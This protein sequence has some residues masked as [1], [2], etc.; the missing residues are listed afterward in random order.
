MFAEAESALIERITAAAIV[1]DPFPH[2]VVDDIF[3]PD[4]YGSLHEHWPP[5]DRFRPLVETG[6][7]DP[8]YSKQRLALLL[9][10]D[11]LARLDDIPQNFWR[12]VCSLLLDSRLTRTI[13]EKF[14]DEIAARMRPR[15]IPTE[16]EA[17][18]DLLADRAGYALGPHTDTPTRVVSLLFY[19]PLDDRL[20]HCGTALYRPIVPG[21]R[22]AGGPHYDADM[23][24]RVRTVGFV[25]NRLLMFPKTDRSFHG[26]EPIEELV[27]RR[28]LQYAI[29]HA[30]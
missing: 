20:S 17:S 28:S 5:A 10:P 29:R 2:C 15:G 8:D 1:R 12:R 3:P 21:F 27:D 30:G 22:C 13:L 24:S 25:P 11:S 23:F 19:L 6:R 9:D 4:F 18:V 14:H 7:V 26:V 16:F